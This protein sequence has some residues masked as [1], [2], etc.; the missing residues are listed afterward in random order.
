MPS[1]G[2]SELPLAPVIQI[3]LG[4]LVLLITMDSE[5]AW[6]SPAMVMLSGTPAAAVASAVPR[7]GPLLVTMS[8]TRG[9]GGDGTGGGCAGGDAG[10]AGGGKHESELQRV[11]ESMEHPEPQLPPKA[12]GVVSSFTVQ[13][14]YP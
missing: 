11:A 13:S 8:G 9:G 4:K 10:G 1:G 6:V 5:A 12:L 7:S 2:C 14:L 3:S